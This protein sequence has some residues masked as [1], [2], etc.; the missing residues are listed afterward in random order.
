[1]KTVLITGDSGFLGRHLK[2]YLESLG[3]VIKVSNTKVANLMDD[4]NLHIYNDI[5]FDYIFH[6]AAHTKAGDYCLYHKGEQFLINQLINTNI[7]KYWKE[8]QSQ[9]KMIAMGT[10][11]SYAPDIEMSEKN[12][13]IGE[14]EDGLYT[15]AMTKRMLL[16]GLKSLSEQYGLKYLYYIPSTLYGPKFDLNDSHFIFD[17]I[18]KIYNGKFNNDIVELWGDGHQKRELVYIDDAISNMINTIEL[19]NEIFNI[20]SGEEHTIRE[21]ANKICDIL[22]YDSDKIIYN[23]N[24]Y[25]GVKSKKLFP[26]KLNSIIN[27]SQKTKLNDGLYTT[28]NYFKNKI[29]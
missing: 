2:S 15:Y 14:P 8:F 22:D 28:I 13:L 26:N 23:E 6:L 21:F 18:K 24:K 3:W 29:Q 25:V 9:S 17:L 20:S 7:L 1:M 10:S 4:K 12:Y 16:I 11:C 19:E 27:K 5:K